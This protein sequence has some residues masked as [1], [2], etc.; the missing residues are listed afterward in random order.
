VGATGRRVSWRRVL[1][2]ILIGLASI[3]LFVSVM[4]IWIDFSALDTD[5]F[6]ETS[7][8]ILADPE[9]QESLAPY[10]VNQIFSSVDVKSSLEGVLPPALDR[11]AGP[12]AAG[13]EE[14][15]LRTARRLLASAQFQTLWREATRAAHE[16]FITIVEGDSAAIATI[17]GKVVLNLRPM[18]ER[19]FE[20]IGLDPELVTRLPVGIGQI[21]VVEESQLT[22][23][24]KLVDVLQK[25]AKWFWVFALLLYVGAVWLARGRRREA[26]RGV[27]LSW[28][29]VGMGLVVLVR[30]GGPRVVETL[31]AVP[32]N[33]SAAQSV[34][35]ILTA[36]L[37]D[38]ARALLLVGAVVLVGAWLAGPGRRATA[39]RRWLAPHM[40]ERPVLVYGAVALAVLLILLFAPLRENR[41]FLATIVF[42]GFLALGVETIRRITIREFP[43]AQPDEGAPPQESAPRQDRPAG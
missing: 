3:I 20:R 10:L 15:A 23:V 41:T 7:G 17:D 43:S 24:Q 12:V 33:E 31:V 21:T 36:N 27:G 42:L 34:W 9:V 6:T 32:A 11:L 40:R 28:L 25:I 16:E 29:L 13:L 14:V 22:A 37:R 8:E 4:A 26:I 18:T 38:S 30:L 5:E 35:N 39:A 1:S 2:P 19:I